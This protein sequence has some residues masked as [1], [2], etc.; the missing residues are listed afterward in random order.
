M[1]YYSK[2]AVF[3]TLR[4]TF[5]S[6][7]AINV[8]PLYTIK[9]LMGHKTLTMTERYAHLIPDHKNQAVED[10]ADIFRKAQAQTNEKVRTLKEEVR[11][12]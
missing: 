12:G 1:T 5:E 3:H 8:T 2:K 11:H 4:H 7:L 6:W 9:E 10:M